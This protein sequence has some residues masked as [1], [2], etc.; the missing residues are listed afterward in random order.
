MH[1]FIWKT[2]VSISV[3]LCI[4]KTTKAY[5]NSKYNSWCQGKDGIYL[6]MQK[7]YQRLRQ[8]HV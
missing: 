2:K 3:K 4:G 1:T 7:R 5:G 8:S 6:D